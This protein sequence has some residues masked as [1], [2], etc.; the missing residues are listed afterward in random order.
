MANWLFGVGG[1][2]TKLHDHAMFRSIDDEMSNPNTLQSHFESVN[3]CEIFSPNDCF[4]LVYRW[5]AINQILWRKSVEE[6]ADEEEERRTRI[7]DI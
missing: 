1:G 5:L 4:T 6:D 7:R 2:R 3:F